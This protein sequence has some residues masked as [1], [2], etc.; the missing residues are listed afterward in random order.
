MAEILLAGLQSEHHSP[1]RSLTNIM[2]SHFSAPSPH[3]C[4]VNYFGLKFNNI[5]KRENIILTIY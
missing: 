4:L 1:F 5:K 3:K 2:I